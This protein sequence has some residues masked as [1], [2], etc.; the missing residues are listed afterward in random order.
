MTADRKPYLDDLE[1]LKSFADT[2]PNSRMATVAK[3]TSTAVMN[4]RWERI[5]VDREFPEHPWPYAKRIVEET[6][7][8]LQ[9][10]G[11]ALF[12]EGGSEPL[13][14]RGGVHQDGL[15]PRGTY[16]GGVDQKRSPLFWTFLER[17]SVQ[18]D[19]VLPG[20]VEKMEPKGQSDRDPI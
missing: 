9:A 10:W 7:A 6:L 14:P 3:V 4:M 1:E 19:C 16:Q 20:T 11:D 12:I 2:L 15:D 17:F 18:A 5:M 8:Q 13:G